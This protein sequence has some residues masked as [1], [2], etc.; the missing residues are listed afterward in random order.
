MSMQMV[1]KVNGLERRIADL[2]DEVA[3]MRENMVKALE[4]VEVPRN[5]GGRPKGSKNKP[6]VTEDGHGPSSTQPGLPERA[7]RDDRRQAGDVMDDGQRGDR[8]LDGSGSG[9]RAAARRAQEQALK[10]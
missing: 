3:Q 10:G 5:K 9:A 7:E 6:K 2:E 4:P 8:P 1:I